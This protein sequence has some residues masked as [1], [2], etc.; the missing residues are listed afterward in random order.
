MSETM[1]DEERAAAVAALH[2]RTKPLY[3]RIQRNEVMRASL[4]REN[5]RLMRQI[6]DL[7]WPPKEEE[8]GK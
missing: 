4:E 6:Q 3:D 5:R 8:R 2:A 7:I 1:T